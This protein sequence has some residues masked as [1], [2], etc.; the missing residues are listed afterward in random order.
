MRVQPPETEDLGHTK[1]REKI[2]MENAISRLGSGIKILIA[3]ADGRPKTPKELEE[4]IGRSENTVR[5]WTIRLAKAG[6]IEKIAEG[7]VTLDSNFLTSGGR[8]I[9]MRA[10]TR[11]KV[12]EALKE[13]RAENYAKITLLDV[14]S[15]TRLPPRVIE[16]DTYLL[17]HDHGLAVAAESSWRPDL[18][19][20]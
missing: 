16:D 4:A 10:N 3:L 11:K 13:L 2:Y 7:W 19:L 12:N 8:E 5:T 6:M 14:S 17:A 20:A 9:F 15:K 1:K 18:S